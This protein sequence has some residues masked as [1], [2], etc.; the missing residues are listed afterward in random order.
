MK[1]V[2][3]SS[4]RG[5]VEPAGEAKLDEPLPLQTRRRSPWARAGR[6]EET[7]R[8][9]RVWRR[10]P[11]LPGSTSGKRFELPSQVGDLVAQ[12]ACVLE[13]ELLRRLVHLLLQGLDEP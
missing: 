8:T 11:L 9:L 4:A 13:P 12:A 3:T 5:W 7:G 10:S 2:T 6:A 1:A